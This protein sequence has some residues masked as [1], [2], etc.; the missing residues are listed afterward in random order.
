MAASQRPF[1]PAQTPWWAG[2]HNQSQM[3]H[4]PHTITAN[5]GQAWIPALALLLWVHRLM[6]LSMP[7]YPHAQCEA[8]GL[9]CSQSRCGTT[10]DNQST[11]SPHRKSGM[12]L[13]AAASRDWLLGGWY[14]HP[15]GWGLA[16]SGCSAKGSHHYGLSAGKESWTMCSGIPRASGLGL[17]PAAP[18]GSQPPLYE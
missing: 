1:Q 9:L 11:N 14:Q 7:Q 2:G 12:W 4:G 15:R 8:R 13:S 6:Y 10:R 16:C 3:P 5:P 17:K 18:P